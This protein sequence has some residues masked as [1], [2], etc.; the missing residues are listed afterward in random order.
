[1]DYFDDIDLEYVIPAIVITAAQ[2][3]RP[4]NTPRNTGQPGREYLYKLLEGGSSKRIYE[5]LRMQKETFLKLCDWL[6]SNTTLQSSRYITIQEQ[7]AM[8]L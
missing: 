6:E 5:V 4:E 7:V 1:M 8:F 3:I 2:T